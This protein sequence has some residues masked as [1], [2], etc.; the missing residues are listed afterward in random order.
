MP[1]VTMKKMHV[2]STWQTFLSQLF[3]PLV[4]LLYFCEWWSM[5]LLWLLLDSAAANKLCGLMMVC[6]LAEGAGDVDW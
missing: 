6:V 1:S 3:A 4:L 2:Q 5:L